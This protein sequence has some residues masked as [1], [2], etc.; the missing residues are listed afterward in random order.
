MKVDRAIEKH[1]LVNQKS[2]EDSEETYKNVV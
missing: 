1:D 2:Y